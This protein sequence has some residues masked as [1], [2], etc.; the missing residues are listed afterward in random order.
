ML[1]FLVQNCVTKDDLKGAVDDMKGSVDTL[2][3]VVGE[4]EYR[5]KDHVSREVAKIRDI[6]Y[7]QNE[8]TNEVVRVIQ[9]E[10]A[11]SKMDGVRLIAIN[12][13]KD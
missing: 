7:R 8:K 1:R 2:R 4:S 6:E 11:I 3:G 5:L 12:P 9:K 13:F 10:A